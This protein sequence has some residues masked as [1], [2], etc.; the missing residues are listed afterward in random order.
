MAVEDRAKE[1]NTL[2]EKIQGMFSTF[3]SQ[4][5]SI[6]NKTKEDNKKYCREEEKRCKIKSAS[7]SFGK[8]IGNIKSKVLSDL[9]QY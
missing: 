9:V 3:R 8:S 6:S 2:A 5:K 7:S 4:F 1:L